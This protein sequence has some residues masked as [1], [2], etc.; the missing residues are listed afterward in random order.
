MAE[1]KALEY[2]TLRTP[3]LFFNKKHTINRKCID[4]ILTQIQENANNMERISH[5]KISKKYIAEHLSQL[6]DHLNKFKEISSHE[7]LQIAR[8]IKIR[9]KHLKKHECK[10]NSRWQLYF[11]KKK[12]FNRMLVDYLIRNSYYNTAFRLAEKTDVKKLTNVEF[13]S[14][15]HEIEKSLAKQETL[16]CSKWC[17]ENRYKLRKIKSDLE[18]KLRL[19]EF[20]LLIKSS[21]LH[22]ALKHSRKYFSKFK[23]K[24]LGVIQKVMTLLI[25]PTSK[26]EQYNNF[27]DN[28]KWIDLIVQF[29]CDYYRVYNLPRY[30]IFNSVLKAGLSAIK[31]SECYSSDTRKKN[32]DCPVC[33]PSLNKL[34]EELPY[35]Y[36]SQS[37]LFC[38]INGMALDENNMPFVLPNGN[39]YG[40][41]GLKESAEKNKGNVVC[42]VTG[43]VYPISAIEKVY[44][45]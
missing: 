27:F 33:D 6:T 44:V 16:K 45:M 25:Y 39:V 20:V 31:T 2:T 4:N 15:M 23:D 36:C 29:K 35:A 8:N 38:R 40:E 42:P 3:Y 41:V 32:P 24:H 7:E 37:K 21:K 34:A 19:Q 9:L 10:K 18:F 43:D 5:E 12:R 28:N 22:L 30:S 11:W 17:F 26:F 13:T 14:T 1:L